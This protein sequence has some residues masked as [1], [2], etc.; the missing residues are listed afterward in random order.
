[1]R[2]YRHNRLQ[3]ETWDQVPKEGHQAKTRRS[4]TG[5]GQESHNANEIANLSL[6]GPRPERGEGKRK[7]EVGG[8]RGEGGEGGGRKRLT[9]D[10]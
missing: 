5:T 4:P 7:K 9:G 8:E 6:Q 2:V 3:A 10:W 1:M